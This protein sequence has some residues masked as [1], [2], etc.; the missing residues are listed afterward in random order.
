MACAEKKRWSWQQ[1]QVPMLWRHRGQVS[2]IKNYFSAPATICP[3]PSTNPQA[4]P[5]SRNPSVP[6]YEVKNLRNRIA[7]PFFSKI[8]IN[9]K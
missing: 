1:L 7:W 5:T 8:L 3:N 9:F 2:F 6:Q 4:L